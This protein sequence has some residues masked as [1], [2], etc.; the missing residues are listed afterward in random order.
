MNKLS[1]YKWTI[2][3][4]VVLNLTTIGTILVHHTNEKQEQESILIEPENDIRVNGRYF[5]QVIGFD[6]Q[7]MEEFR[8]IN[9][10]FQPEARK[11]LFQIDS[12]KNLS[13]EVLNQPA[14]D[15]A[16][17]NSIAAEIGIRHAQLKKVTHHFYLQLRE[18][19]TDEQAIHLQQV[20][21]PLFMSTSNSPM[22][23]QRSGR[24]N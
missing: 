2:A 21:S 18:L 6:N 8:T 12:L 19:S 7:Q 23:N 10:K 15:T 13:F 9:R 16:Q 22:S 5:R 20:F 1:V 4:L 3:L 11:V 14:P 24:N 17:L